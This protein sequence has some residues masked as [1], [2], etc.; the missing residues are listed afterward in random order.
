MWK[1]KTKIDSDGKK[2]KKARLVARGCKQNRNESIYAHVPGSTAIKTFLAITANRQL[3]LQMDVKAA[4]LNSYLKEEVYMTI[5]KGFPVEGSLCRLK[6]AIYGLRQA[7]QAWINELESF[8]RE[9]NFSNSEVDTYLYRKHEPDNGE[10]TYVL[11]YVDD[12]LIA[13][14]STEGIEKFK[15][16]LKQ[17]YKTKEIPEIKRFVG[18]EIKQTESYI[19]ICQTSHVKKLL[20]A[21]GLEMAK[22][23]STPMEPNTK[24]VN[25]T[26]N[27]ECETFRTKYRKLIGNL[28][29]L[30]QHT[31]PD[32]TYS[33][34]YLSRFQ[35]NP[36]EEHYA[37][38]KRII[39]YLSRTANYVVCYTPKANQRTYSDTPTPHGKRI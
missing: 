1:F 30:S 38:V 15:T 25:S 3:E 39:R 8:M 5:P 7:S 20:Q 23:R 37:A 18:L 6:K 9:N 16:R 12:I 11:Q 24:Y 17:R 10:I 14:S 31:R 26:C 19:T 34:N 32:I 13:S 22:P 27:L 2:V 33:V 4:Y 35:S 21:S 28:L 29:Y 36:T